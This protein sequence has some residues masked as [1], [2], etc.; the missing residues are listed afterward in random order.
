MTFND[1]ITLDTS[2][3]NR[4]GHRGAKVG[5]GI[6]GLGLIGV[7]LYVVLTGQIPD[8][9]LLGGAGSGLNSDKP[10]AVGQLAAECRTGADANRN[11]YCRMVA[12]KNSLDVF[13]AAQLQ[14]EKGVRYV[15]A[16]LVLYNG[17]TATACGTGSANMGPF[18]CPGDT[19]VYIDVSFYDQLSRM[20]A[21]NTSLAQL[22]IL[23][24]EWGHHI[25]HQLGILRQMDRTSRG[26]NSDLVRSELQADC[27]AGA[28]IHH[29]STT[30]DPDT[31]VAFMKRPTQ[32]QLSSAISAAAAVGDDRIYESAG[33][34]AN[35][36]NFSHGSAEKRMKWL[37][38]GIAGGTIAACNTWS[39]RTL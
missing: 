25:Q 1:N 14:K 37:S 28:W 13:W 34:R 7:I 22:Y 27:L 15:P 3:V 9:S 8:L 4:S 21:H 16:G 30:I 11:P 18:Y 26:E 19:T 12:G 6:G 10:V 33:M 5:G 17:A 31:G 20:G 24:H 36:D 38:A 2:G 39:A 29:A 23:A 32:A 35:P